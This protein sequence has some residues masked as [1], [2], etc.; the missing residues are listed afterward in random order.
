MVAIV[1]AL[2]SSNRSLRLQSPTPAADLMLVMLR[3]C[4][5]VASAA[6]AY[7]QNRERTANLYFRLA[8]SGEL[9]A[10]FTIPA[11]YLPAGQS[12]ALARAVDCPD[13]SLVRSAYSHRPEV[14]C[15]VA[16]PSPLSMRAGLRLSELAATLREAGVSGLDLILTLPDTGSMRLDRLC[17]ALTAGSA[18][19]FGP[20]RRWTSFPGS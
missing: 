16:R 7:G 18:H 10:T 1:S 6:L 3:V 19:T 12:S 4:L 8:S 17:H 9:H 13:S 20:T 14:R 2:L 5:I 11:A 15:A